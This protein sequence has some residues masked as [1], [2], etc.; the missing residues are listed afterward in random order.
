ML[1]HTRYESK[2]GTP[3]VTYVHPGDHKFP[4]E[5]AAAVV[6]FFK[7]NAKK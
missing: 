4:P 6:K 2:A 1:N 5:V 7:E 3:V